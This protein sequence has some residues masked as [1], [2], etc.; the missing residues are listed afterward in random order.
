MYLI[1]AYKLT[2]TKVKN[3]SQNFELIT[4]ALGGDIKFTEQRTVAL[5]VIL[6]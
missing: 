6:Q 1:L 2:S 4:L 5:P 3:V